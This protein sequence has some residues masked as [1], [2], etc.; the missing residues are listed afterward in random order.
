MCI[1]DRLYAEQSA[2]ADIV[3]TTANIPGRKSPVLLTAADV[4]A[5]KPGSVIVDM[6]AANGGNCELT[7]PGEVT[8]TDGGV[9]VIGYTDLAGR[10]PGQA[11]QLYGQNVVNLF[12]LITPHKDGKATLDLGDEIVRQITLTA[13]SRGP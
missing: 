11:S 5:M 6:A 10:L 12:K 3:I 2:A 4:A 7:V 8:V 1:R 13:S 9:T